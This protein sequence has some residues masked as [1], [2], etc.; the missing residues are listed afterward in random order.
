MPGKQWTAEA[1]YFYFTTDRQ[2]LAE[3]LPTELKQRYES[4]REAKMRS[5]PQLYC[6]K[7]EEKFGFKYNKGNW[8]LAHSGLLA[9]VLNDAG[10]PVELMGDLTRACPEGHG[11]APYEPAATCRVC[12]GLGRVP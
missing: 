12:W 8:V 11:A 6:S 3:R 10:F 7:P 4:L 2:R 9:R 5:S 1:V